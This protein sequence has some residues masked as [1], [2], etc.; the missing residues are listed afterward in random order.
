MDGEIK[1][2]LYKDEGLDSDGYITSKD[3][4]RLKS[5]L[6]ANVRVVCFINY[7][8]SPQ[9]EYVFQD[10]CTAIKINSIYP[11]YQFDARGITY[12]S[13]REIMPITFEEVCE[14]YG[15]EFMEP[16]AQ[17]SQLAEIPN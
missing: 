16:T 5:L 8:A 13:W 17:P 12:A 4:A 2:P 6:D 15:V 7:D 14:Q 9:T 1:K 11:S 10:V 3:Y